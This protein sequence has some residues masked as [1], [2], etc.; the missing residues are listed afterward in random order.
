[1]PATPTTPAPVAD[2]KVVQSEPPKRKVN[3]EGTDSESRSSSRISKR[4]KYST[5]PA[6]PANPVPVDPMAPPKALSQ[7]LNLNGMI[8]YPDAIAQASEN[9]RTLSRAV[10]NEQASRKDTFEAAL[11]RAN[12]RANDAEHKLQDMSQSY[13][14]KL[15]AKEEAHASAVES[16]GVENAT[17]SASLSASRESLQ[18]LSESS[19]RRAALDDKHAQLAR[20]DEILP[21]LT[22]EAA[23]LLDVRTR[24]LSHAAAIVVQHETLSDLIRQFL[25]NFEEVSMKRLKGY[26]IEIQDESRAM[27]ERIR[28]AKAGWEGLS[29]LAEIFWNGFNGLAEGKGSQREE[30]EEEDRGIRDNP[31]VKGNETEG[32]KDDDGREEERKAKRGKEGEQ[33]KK[34]EQEKGKEEDVIQHAEN[35]TQTE[36]GE[37]ARESEETSKET[38]TA[39]RG[40]DE[41]MEVDLE[42][43]GLGTESK[44]HEGTII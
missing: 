5:E 40:V 36:H 26:G 32:S 6:E 33:E 25:E 30:E 13:A 24:A 28:E 18:A 7:S 15:K 16:L 22:A 38:A 14:D 1:M 19:S 10:L 41:L 20:L 3:G 11:R 17:L 8:F 44:R 4:R 35:Q 34:N 39:M 31:I 27:G 43:R 42:T 23:K 12:R 37:E 2:D 21:P 29:E 9:F